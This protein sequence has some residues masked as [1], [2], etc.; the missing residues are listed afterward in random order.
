MVL[1]IEAGL[2]VLAL[3]LALTTPN[4]GGR[5]FESLERNLSNL[6]WQRGL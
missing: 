5:W 4:L 1:A 3:V 6:A 2:A